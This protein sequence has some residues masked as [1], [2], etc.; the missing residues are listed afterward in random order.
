MILQSKEHLCSKTFHYQES[1]APKTS[2]MRVLD[3]KEVTEGSL[4]L[5]KNSNFGRGG[6]QKLKHGN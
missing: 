4:S 6:P 2:H 1:P 5:K 3:H